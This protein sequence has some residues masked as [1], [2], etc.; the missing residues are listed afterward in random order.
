MV[1][2]RGDLTVKGKRYFLRMIKILIFFIGRVILH[3]YTFVKLLY[4]LKSVHVI[5]FEFYLN[6]TSK[7]CRLFY[8]MPF[9]H[10]P[11]VILVF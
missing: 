6:E 9:F 7:Y 2:F 10:P 4:L 11:H 5:A 3:K 1:A 8:I